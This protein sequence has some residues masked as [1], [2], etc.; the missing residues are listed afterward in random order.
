MPIFYLEMKDPSALRPAAVPALGL[1]VAR[2]SVKQWEV[3]RFLYQWVGG[4]WRWTDRLIW[5]PEQWQ[6]CIGDPGLHTWLATS[7]GSLAGYYELRQ[8]GGE[9]EILYFGLCPGFLGQGLGG[10][11]LTHAIRSAWEL[12]PTRVWVHTCDQDHP[13]ALQNYQSRGMTLYRTDP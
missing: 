2:M 6:A 3:N 4:A 13:A 9:V 7:G 8:E 5:T 12:N 1:Q 11:L 10:H